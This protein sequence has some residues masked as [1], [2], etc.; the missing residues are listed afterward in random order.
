MEEAGAF[1]VEVELVPQ[2]VLEMINT[3]TSLVTFSIGSGSGGDVTFLFSEDICGETA[4]PPRHAHAYGNVRRLQEQIEHERI[5][6]LKAFQA[7]VRDG[8]FPYRDV[9]LAMKPAELEEFR[10]RLAAAPILGRQSKG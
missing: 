9:S 7:G 4:D 6:A 2:E 10:M 1:A 8:S 3:Q 5:E